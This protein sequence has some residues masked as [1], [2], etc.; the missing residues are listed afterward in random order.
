MSHDPSMDVGRAE[1]DLLQSAS[2]LKALLIRCPEARTEIDD[3]TID[4]T[5]CEIMEIVGLASTARDIAER[6]RRKEAA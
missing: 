4:R 2:H 6:R 1:W 5:V 3:A